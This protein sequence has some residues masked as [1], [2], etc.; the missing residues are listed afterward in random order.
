MSRCY[1]L[2]SICWTAEKKNSSSVPLAA[3]SPSSVLQY[4][5][6]ESLL[7]TKQLLLLGAA[8]GPRVCC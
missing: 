6:N 2:R 4:L 8:A 5:P 3:L 7:L 1:F